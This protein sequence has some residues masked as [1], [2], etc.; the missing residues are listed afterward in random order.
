MAPSSG[1]RID[2]VPRSKVKTLTPDSNGSETPDLL[3][4]AVPAPDHVD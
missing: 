3:G 2:T 1:D 4:A